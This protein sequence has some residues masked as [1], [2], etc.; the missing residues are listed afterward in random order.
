MSRRN[1]VVDA[2]EELDA[3]IAVVKKA[4]EKD[5]KALGAAKEALLATETERK[6]LEDRVKFLKKARIVSLKE[7]ASI[8]RRIRDLTE[9]DATLLP[10]RVA[11][12]AK[13]VASLTSKIEYLKERK[14]PLVDEL[15]SFGQLINL[16][17]YRDGRS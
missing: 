15:N 17:E 9:Y 12:L 3:T 2:I 16:E 7:W 1:E 14:L 6:R 10:L 11:D 5:K 4:L 8:E 13:V